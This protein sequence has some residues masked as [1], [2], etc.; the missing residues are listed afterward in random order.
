MHI[1]AG[2]IFR[3]GSKIG[4]KQ[5]R[6]LNSKFNFMQYVFFK[7]VYAVYTGV[8]GKAPE[9]GKFSRIFALKVTLRSERLLLTV[10]LS[11]RIKLGEQDV[12]VAPP[13]IL[14]PSSPVSADQ[15]LSKLDVIHWCM[16]AFHA[17][18]DHR[19]FFINLFC[20]TNNTIRQYIKKSIQLQQ[21]W[22]RSEKDD[23]TYSHPRMPITL[24]I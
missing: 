2:T 3:L 9:A 24:V 20:S 12:L 7:K 11:F 18:I 21:S 4:E 6:Q 13:V 5:S 16:T 17:S 22:N 23:S 19:Q 8:W 1:G 14:L 15:A 10:G